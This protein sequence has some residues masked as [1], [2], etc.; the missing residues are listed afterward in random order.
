MEKTGSVIKEKCFNLQATQP[1]Q[2]H[3]DKFA[4]V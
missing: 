1:W 3:A 4:I 2:Q